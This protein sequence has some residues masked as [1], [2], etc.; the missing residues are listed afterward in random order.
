MAN[1]S[2]ELLK[3]LFPEY[4][5]K[6]CVDERGFIAKSE[7]KNYASST[8]QVHTQGTVQQQTAPVMQP[9]QNTSNQSVR[10]PAKNY[11]PA[12]EDAKVVNKANNAFE[13]LSGELSKY[14]VGSDKD[15][16]SLC[17]AFQRPYVRGFD[18]VKPKNAILILGSESRGKLYA[19]RC[20]TELL[21]EKKVF[22]YNQIASMDMLDYSADATNALFLSDLYKSLNTNTESVVFENI[23]KASLTQLD[24]IWQL[25]TEGTYKLSKRY[26]VSNGSLMEATGV[27]NTELI[28]EISSNGKF[29]CSHLRYRKQR[30][31]RYLVIR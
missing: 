9:I 17:K 28:S 13:N 8:S 15:K 5:I 16:V 22:R 10:M 2:K 3:F 27:L 29:L 21:K 18:N 31:F 7:K 19:V 26:M 6:A 11:T 12:K 4:Q 25:L 24:I 30:L 23:E 20:I 14:W 1:K